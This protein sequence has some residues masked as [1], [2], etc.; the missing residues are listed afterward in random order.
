MDTESTTIDPRHTD[1]LIFDMDGTLWDATASYCEIW[2]VCFAR[3]GV[4]FTLT[5]AD[6]MAYMGLTID[7]IFDDVARRTGVE[8]DRREFLNEISVVE[9]EMMPTL[10]GK[11]FDGVAEG[12][13]RL[14]KHYRLFMVSNCSRY[15]L[16][17]FM[18]FT[19]TTEFFTDSLS[20]GE[21]RVPKSENIGELI[22][23]HGLRNAVYVGDTQGDCYEAHR[24]GTKFVYAAYGFGDCK[25]YDMKV[26]NFAELVDYFLK[27]KEN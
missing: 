5:D 23:R 7:A 20:F 6:I 10:G 16:R 2:R 3:R 12:L 27:M 8:F 21:R 4:E 15:G 25:G 17:N 9:D 14:S 11:L 13:G 18:T 19:H 24:A 22:S 26:D 1:A